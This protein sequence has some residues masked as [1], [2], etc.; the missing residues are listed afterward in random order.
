MMRVVSW[1]TVGALAEV[2]VE[3]ADVTVGDDWEGR[4]Q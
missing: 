3:L 2:A 1:A 4:Q